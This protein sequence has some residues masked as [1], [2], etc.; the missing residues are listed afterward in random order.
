MNSPPHRQNLMNPVFLDVGF[1]YAN[2]ANFVGSGEETVVVAMY[3]AQSGSSTPA[4]VVTPP[5]PVAQVQ[6]N[7]NTPPA[8]TAQ[9]A[10][11]EPI[12]T[13]VEVPSASD[14]PAPARQSFPAGLPDSPALPGF[15][16]I[17]RKTQWRRAREPGRCK[18]PINGARHARRIPD[19]GSRAGARAALRPERQPAAP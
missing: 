14:T 10:Q 17:A 4:P 18:A 7:T 12:S 9:T 15:R 19:P 16:Y 13:P 6:S 8:Q 5:A 2:S 11:E 3:G 1:G